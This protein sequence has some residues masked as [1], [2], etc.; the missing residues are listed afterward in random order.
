MQVLIFAAGKGTRLRPLTYKTPK[1]LIKINNK[2]LIEHNLEKLPK[3]IDEIILI[4]NYL[5]EKFYDYFGDNFQGRRVKY[6]YQK[7]INGTAGALHYAKK[8]LKERFL[9]LNGDDIYD[10]KDIKKCLQHQNSILIKEK[11]GNF[12]GGKI[13]LDKNNNLENIEEGNHNEKKAYI[14][15]G[16]YVLTKNFFKYKKIQIPNTKEYGLPQTLIEMAKKEE[17]K[18]QKANFYLQ[19]GDPKALKEAK[20]ILKEK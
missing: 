3:E 2:T 16:L 9:V 18:I 17:I 20:K 7:E 6:I 12:S 19:I 5:K 11:K 13:I 14:A 1:P 10:K 15:T 8:I 4:V